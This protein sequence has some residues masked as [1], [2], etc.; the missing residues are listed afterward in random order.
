MIFAF[1]VFFLFYLFFYDKLFLFDQVQII[2]A[3]NETFKIKPK[4]TI[5][6]LSKS[7]NLKVVDLID[8]K[9]TNNNREIITLNSNNT[10]P[11]LPPIKIENEKKLKNKTDQMFKKNIN[12]E[13]KKLKNIIDKNTSFSSV[14][15]EKKI[16]TFKQ[17]VC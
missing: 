5:T 10:L 4:N 6:N 3:T 11:E 16:Q 8:G 2:K 7:E 15:T 17:R 1:P 12:K 13:N 14:N 9:D